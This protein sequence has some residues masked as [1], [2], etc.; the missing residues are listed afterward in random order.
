[1]TAEQRLEILQ[2]VGQAFNRIKSPEEISLI[3]PYAGDKLTKGLMSEAFKTKF[4]KLRLFD[5]HSK[6]FLVRSEATTAL[7]I[8]TQKDGKMPTQRP[9]NYHLYVWQQIVLP[10]HR[11][12][13]FRLIGL[14]ESAIL[15]KHKMGRFP[16]YT[17]TN[18]K[19]R[20]VGKDSLYIHKP[21]MEA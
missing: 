16:L 1:M 18:P 12:S 17:V 7:P 21:L 3:C 11:G 13:I 4:T 20:A 19:L 5:E 2:R 10:R 9:R 6:I 15:T 8:A 14:V